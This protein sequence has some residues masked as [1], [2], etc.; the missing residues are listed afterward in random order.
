MYLYIRKYLYQT[1]KKL[2]IL[3]VLLKRDR[4]AFKRTVDITYVSTR[5]LYYVINS[6]YLHN[7]LG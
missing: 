5:Y 2:D 3:K 6:L 1:R 4:F 7:E